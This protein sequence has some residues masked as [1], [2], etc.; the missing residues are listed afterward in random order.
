MGIRHGESI[1]QAFVSANVDGFK[2]LIRKSI[3]G[4]YKHIMESKNTLVKTIVSSGYFLYSS[5]LFVK[6]K[7]LLFSDK[8]FK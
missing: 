3:Y 6:W 1:S 7:Y 8:V 5:D 2:A 4:F